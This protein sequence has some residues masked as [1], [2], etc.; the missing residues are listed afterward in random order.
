MLY[1]AGP[2]SMCSIVGGDSS[3]HLIPEIVGSRLCT[4]KTSLALS[5]R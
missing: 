2:K 1:C 3:Y 5:I 4:S